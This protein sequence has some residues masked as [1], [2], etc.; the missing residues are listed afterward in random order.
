MTDKAIG[1][2]LVIEALARAEVALRGALPRLNQDAHYCGACGLKK[3]VDWTEHQCAQEIEAM[4]R[5]LEKWQATLKEET[6][7]T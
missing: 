5:K 2:A 4:I 6:Y 7:G 3:K 1:R